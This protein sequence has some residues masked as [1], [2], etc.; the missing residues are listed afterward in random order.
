VLTGPRPPQASPPSYRPEGFPEII[1]YDGDLS[2]MVGRLRS[3]APRC[4]I[5]GCESGVELAEQLAPRVLPDR[6]N[7]PGLAQAR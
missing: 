7:V 2:S 6:A 3:L 4:I 1:V 5:A